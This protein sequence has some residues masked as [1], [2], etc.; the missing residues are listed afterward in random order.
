VVDTSIVRRVGESGIAVIQCIY[1][2][3]SG[4]PGPV[5]SS[6]ELASPER[7][8]MHRG[9]SGTLLAVNLAELVLQAQ[10][11][12]GIIEFVPEV[13][14]FVAVDEPRIRFRVV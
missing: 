8:V 2:E 6:R 5:E 12:N 3:I 10:H 9:T 7:T 1:P 13:G 11:T 14:D 4:L